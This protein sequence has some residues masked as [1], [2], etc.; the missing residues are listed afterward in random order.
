[1]TKY[2]KAIDQ[3]RRKF[4][5]ISVKLNQIDDQCHKLENNNLLLSRI[6]RVRAHKTDI[7]RIMR[8]LEVWLNCKV[9]R[10]NDEFHCS[11][12]LVWGV[13]EDDPHSPKMEPTPR[14]LRSQKPA[15]RQ[16]G[17]KALDRL[18]DDLSISDN[19]R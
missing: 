6:E 9:R 2:Q 16:L 12:G 14:M 8:E 13:K 4:Q 3:I 10:Y 7:Q 11:C 19:R 15:N 5:L 18:L 17:E 1:M